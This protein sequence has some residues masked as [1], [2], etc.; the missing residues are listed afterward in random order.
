MTP[1]PLLFQ[2]SLDQVTVTLSNG[3]NFRDFLDLP[4]HR[5]RRYHTALTAPQSSAATAGTAAAAPT[6]STA[7]N[8]ATAL[9]K[10]LLI[11]ISA[12]TSLALCVFAALLAPSSR[13]SVIPVCQRPL[14][15]VSP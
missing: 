13:H 8:D 7:V 14:A 15:P 11:F 10:T 4:L 3:K 2:V 1:Y 5:L 6:P 12:P 9:M